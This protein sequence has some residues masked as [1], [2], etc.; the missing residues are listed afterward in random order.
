MKSS[1]KL[2][3][4]KRRTDVEGKIITIFILDRASP[5]LLPCTV[6]LVKP[7]GTQLPQAVR[8]CFVQTSHTPLFQSLDW[9]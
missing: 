7:K 1:I 5:S 4:T 2:G 6:H 8:F 9:C 3:N